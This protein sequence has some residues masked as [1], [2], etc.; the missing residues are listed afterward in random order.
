MIFS[1]S[2]DFLKILFKNVPF[3]QSGNIQVVCFPP[4]E[5]SVIEGNKIVKAEYL[6]EKNSDQ[7]NY[8]NIIDRLNS[9]GFV[10][11]ITS[12][13]EESDIGNGYVDEM[14]EGKCHVCLQDLPNEIYRMRFT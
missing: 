6:A 11:I 5:M 9:F 4:K 12:I 3:F 10:C 13:W 2:K 7:W 14:N 1:L 8:Q